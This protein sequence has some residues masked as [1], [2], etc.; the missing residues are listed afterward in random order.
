MD[1]TKENFEQEVLKS[2][3]PV[4]VDFWAAWCGPCKAISPI[5]EE[6]GQEFAGK[7]KVVKVNV[8]EQNELAMQYGIMSIPTLKFF[9]GGQIVGEII[10]AAP[11][12][13]IVAELQKHL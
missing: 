12:P 13:S 11:K 2:G 7:A 5:V 8:D 6:L 10:G 4:I 9:K 1:I 3:Q